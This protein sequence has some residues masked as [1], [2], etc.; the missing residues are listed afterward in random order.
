MNQPSELFRHCPQCGRARAG[1]GPVQPFHC[2]GCGFH[3][4][5]NAAPAVAAFVLDGA[6]RALFVRR[7]R[8]P[9]RGMLAVPGGFVDLGETAEAA[10]R[11]EIREE[12]SLEV[13]PLRFLGT[14]I[15]EYPFRGVA[16]PVLDLFYV[17]E[18][19]DPGR[20]I[21]RD[22]VEGGCWRLPREV[23]PEEIAFPSIRAALRA[24][25]AGAG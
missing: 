3:F 21:A 12:V 20:M 14:Q 19:I 18:A 6:G 13:G 16:Y 25:L 2:E 22:E 4:Y 5:F 8:E 17:A 9:A 15:N 24:Y 23:A 10:L 11:R 1:Q 7:T